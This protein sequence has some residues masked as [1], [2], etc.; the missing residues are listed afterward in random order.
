MSIAVR[1]LFVK[2][3]GKMYL[4]VEMFLAINHNQ[5]TLEITNCNQVDI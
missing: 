3:K 1:H 2:K 5:I 4:N